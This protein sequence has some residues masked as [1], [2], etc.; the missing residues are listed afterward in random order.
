MQHKMLRV[1]L[2][3]WIGSYLDDGRKSEEQAEA[4]GRGGA[5]P[6]AQ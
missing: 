6:I 3:C 2:E 5:R 4:E 1:P